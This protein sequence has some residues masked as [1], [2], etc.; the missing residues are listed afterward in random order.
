MTILIFLVNYKKHLQE[1]SQI[2]QMN[3]VLYTTSSK[4]I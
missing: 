1:V 3:H 4:A 2:V